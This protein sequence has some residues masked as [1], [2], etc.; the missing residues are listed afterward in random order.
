MDEVTETEAI[1]PHIEPS[2]SL[3]TD[4]IGKLQQ[5]ATQNSRPFLEPGVET[6]SRANCLAIFE[7]TNYDENP[8]NSKLPFSTFIELISAELTKL[9][10]II[11]CTVADGLVVFADDRNM[12]LKAAV[13]TLN[14]LV[15]YNQIVEE[16][17]VIYLHVT[18]HASQAPFLSLENEGLRELRKGFKIHGLSLNSSTRSE[19]SHKNV[20]RLVV[21]ETMVEL[22]SGARVMDLGSFHLPH[23]PSEHQI[24]EINLRNR[25]ETTKIS[26]I[27]NFGKYEILET[28]RENQLYSTHQGYDTQLDR[29]VIIKVY[30]SQA[31]QSFKEF[32]LLRKQFYEEIR[33]LNRINH[34][35]VAVIY[36]AGEKEDKLYLVR[37]YVEGRILNDSLLGS[38]L[39]DINATLEYYILIC[40]ILAYFHKNQVWHKNVKPDNV[41]VTAQDEIKIADG[42][43]L[44][45]R[46]SDRVWNDDVDSQAYSAPEQIQG[47]NLTPTCD[48]FQL[49]VM[50]YESLT[51]THPFRATSASDVRIKILADAPEP[52][53]RFRQDLPE[54]LGRVLMRA[55]DKTPDNR[56]A[57][58]LE[59]SHQLQKISR[60][61]ANVTSSS[62]SD[63]L[64]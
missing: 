64:K 22:F 56:F 42:A 61:N 19:A 6:L 53:S 4:F 16:F 24:Y 3:S 43:L 37:E 36:D 39:P 2:F 47:S 62:V 7:I 34:P 63:V 49:A 12:L 11:V 28:V 13:D 58:I 60:G 59:F 15:R 46:H 38:G 18:M 51:G 5:S 26:K 30:R 17:E 1:L 10:D 8:K 9:S 20:H 21:T 41:F 54:P 55:L 44:Q 23:F 25:Q 45:V 48:V 40:K 32:S 33:R 57:S 14:K 50:L 35:N 27:S 29:T 52:P 31:F